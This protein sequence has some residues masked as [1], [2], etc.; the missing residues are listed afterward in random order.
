M[1]TTTWS[2]GILTG[3]GVVMVVAVMFSVIGTGELAS[4]LPA[5]GVGVL[6]LLA[7]PESVATRDSD[8]TH[9]VEGSVDPRTGRTSQSRRDRDTLDTGD[10]E[11]GTV[12]PYRSLT[13]AQYAGTGVL[14]LLV[15]TPFL[16]YLLVKIRQSGGEVLLLLFLVLVLVIVLSAGS[17]LASVS[18]KILAEGQSLTLTESGIYLASPLYSGYI[19]WDDLVEVHAHQAKT[20]LE[21]HLRAPGAVRSLRPRGRRGLRTRGRQSLRTRGGDRPIHSIGKLRVSALAHRVAGKTLFYLL[22]DLHRHPHLRSRLRGGQIVDHIRV[23][24]SHV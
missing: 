21:I 17:S 12:I 15:V 19:A 5:L 9:V 2:R 20:G 8:L 18:R 6:V 16:I 11:S 7:M 3:L 1:W 23:I 4:A 13:V 14:C 24:A 22:D 10:T